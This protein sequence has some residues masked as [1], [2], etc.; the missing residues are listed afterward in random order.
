MESDLVRLTESVSAARSLE[1]LARPLLEMLHHLTD[2]DSTYVTRID[3]EA[4]TQLVEF[5]RNAG[6]LNIAEH[7]TVPWSDTLCK[8]SFE[9]GRQYT[10]DVPG[11]WPD[12]AAAKALG[13]KTYVSS[14]IRGINGELLGT[15]CAASKRQMPLSDR[16]RSAINLFSKLISQHMERETVLE[17]LKSANQRLALF[18]LT[19]PLTGIPNRRAIS[20]ELSRLLAAARREQTT[21]LVGLVDLD[22]FKG[23]NDLHG[24]EGGDH[25]LREIAIRLSGAARGTDMVG[26]LGGDEFAVVGPGPANRG[27]AHIATIAMTER[28]SSAASGVFGIGGTTVNY[29]GASVGFVAVDGSVSVDQALRLADN[30]MYAIKH[31]RKNMENA[32]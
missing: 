10:D 3:T 4:A 30:E 16:A 23:V 8:R 21:V 1:D 6:A 32:R 5:A 28:F 2:Y 26:R 11:H 17:Q 13:I 20:D 22:S 18:A 24:H 27:D 25:L 29:P 7:M 31:R 19:D 9:E 15:L 12:S 14:P